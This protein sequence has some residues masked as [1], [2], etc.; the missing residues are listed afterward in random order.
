MKQIKKHKF[1][2]ACLLILIVLIAGLC[3]RSARSAEARRAEEIKAISDTIYAR[4]LQCY[5]IEG[6][7]PESLRYLEENYGL[8]INQQDYRVVYMPFA[9]NLPPEVRVIAREG[10]S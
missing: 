1:I 4:A 2:A 10:S 7:Y 3:I 8:T 6:A 5:V 9:E